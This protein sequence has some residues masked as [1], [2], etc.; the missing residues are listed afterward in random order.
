MLRNGEW[1]DFVYKVSDLYIDI[2]QQNALFFF[3]M[4]DRP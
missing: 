1:E 2:L 4:L 3:F